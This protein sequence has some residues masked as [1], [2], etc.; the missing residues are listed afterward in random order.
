MKTQPVLSSLSVLFALTGIH[1]AR[2]V[3][4]MVYVDGLRPLSANGWTEADEINIGYHRY[5]RGV[6]VDGNSEVEYA[7]SR[8]D[9]RFEAWAGFHKGGA[10]KGAK[11][12]FKVLADGKTV[13]DS[14]VVKF[15]AKNLAM[16]VSVPLDGVKR[17]RLVVTGDEGR[18]DWAEARILPENRVYF[19]PRIPASDPEV[20]KLAMTPMMGVN[21]WNAFGRSINEKL[22][23]ELA[24]CLVDKGLRDLGYR[25]LC[26]DDG[27]QHKSLRD[28]N[29][30]PRWD[31]R[32][33]PSGMKALADYIHSKGLKFGMYSRPK[34]V[35]E[36]NEDKAAGTFAGWEIDFLKYDFS[37]PR[38]IKAMIEATRRAGR[39]VLFN[40]CEWGKRQPWEWAERH[41]AQSWRITYD[42]MDVWYSDGDQNPVGILRSAYQGEALGRYSGP[43]HWNDLDMLVIGLKGKTHLPGRGG[44][45]DEDY[46]SQMSL[47]CL[48][49]SPLAI[50]GDIRNMSEEN[51]AILTNEE[52]IAIDQD[53]LGVPA[54][55]AKKIREQEVWLRPLAN[56][57]YAVG[58]LNV[59]GET[60]RV[61][62]TW[63]EL[64]LRGSFRARDL[65]AHK[66]LGRF[67]GKL[68][69]DVRPHETRLVRLKP[70]R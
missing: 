61:S 2:A 44:A 12:T 58:L 16:K 18:A 46:R 19:E 42:V 64:G 65:W 43:G 20:G 10:R 5:E 13:Y 40:A 33:F 9:G 27:Y 70:V 28:E 37:N 49:A 8:F 17:L 31:E 30:R 53:P 57:E 54:C 47:W 4:G 3:E 69:F 34:W 23:R 67:D 38:N 14:G 7:V 6:A 22:I 48:L 66:E 11:L 68:E 52:V 1:S 25:Y 62:A 60:I 35:K 51:L 56:G 39:P 45:T 15:H 50:G 29:G 59:G 32:K 41:G 63:R 21:T 55:R 26:L 36:G 24:D